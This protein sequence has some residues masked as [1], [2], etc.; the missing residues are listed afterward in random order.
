VT[1][2]AYPA[3]ALGITALMLLLGAFWGLAGGLIALGLAAAL[4]TAATS[5]GTTVGEGRHDYAPTTAAAV[6][7][8]Y[9]FGGGR[10][11]L[12]LSGVTEVEALDGRDISIDGVGGRVEVIVPDG[13]DVSATSQVVG[14][15]SRIFDRRA[16]GFDTTLRGF[17]DGG[18]E[19]PDMT[20]NI[21]LVAGEVIV[22]E[23]A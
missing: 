11:T 23:A 10:F 6:D 4:A 7:D 9:E 18:D 1:D 19:V 2:S 8:S 15:D 13:V 20:I 17:L 12:D 21:D 14:G 5:V 3:L 22:P 16:D